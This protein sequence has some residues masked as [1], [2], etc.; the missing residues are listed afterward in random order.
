M[1][2]ANFTQKLRSALLLIGAI[3]GFSNFAWADLNTTVTVAS[4]TYTPGGTSSVTLEVTIA[5][6]TVEY[7]S[8]LTITLPAGWTGTFNGLGVGSGSCGS[9]TGVVCQDGGNVLIIGDPTCAPADLCGPWNNGTFQ[10]GIDITAPA[11]ATGTQSISW[12]M[13]GDG[14][15]CGGACSCGDWTCDNGTFDLLSS[16]CDIT[17]PADITVDNDPGVC[18]ADVTVPD[19]VVD[20]GCAG[21]PADYITV[22]SPV[23]PYNFDAA[24][25]IA[26]P[27]TVSG[28]TANAVD[29]AVITATYTGD[30]DFFF[31]TE[32]F[33]VTGPDG[34][35]VFDVGISPGQCAQNS[36]TT[37]IPMATWNNWVT[38][39]GA[40]LTFTLQA[41][42]DVDDICA[43]S[44]YQLDVTYPQIL[45]AFSNDFNGGENASGEYPVGTTT[46]TYSTLNTNGDVVS[47]SFNVTVNDVEAPVFQNCPQ[48]MVFNLDPGACNTVVTWPEIIAE[49]NCP[50]VGPA[51]SLIQYSDATIDMSGSLACYTAPTGYWRVFDLAAM[52]I[53]SDFQVNSVSTALVNANNAAF[54][55]RVYTLSGAFTLA[56]L[57]LLGEKTAN[58]T[59]NGVFGDIVFDTPVIVPAGSTMV[60]EVNVLPNAPFGP[61]GQNTTGTETGAS[62][63]SAPSCGINDPVTFASIGFPQYIALIHPNGNVFQNTIPLTNNSD[64][65]P[66]TGQ[67]Y[68]SGDEFPIGVTH[69]SFEATDASGNTSTCD[70]DVIVNEY[71]NPTA[72]LACNDG[73]Q[74][75]LDEDGCSTVGADMVLEGGPY[76]C[77][78]DYIVSIEGGDDVVCCDDLGG[79]WTVKV[80]DPDTGNSCWGSI[81]VEDKLD[82]VIECTDAFI[83]CNEDIAYGVEFT[84][85][86]NLHSGPQPSYDASSMEFTFD[87]SAPL[88]A[89]VNDV[90]VSLD[91]SHTWVSDLNVFLLAP[92]GTPVELFT[93]VCGLDDNIDVTIDDDGSPFACSGGNP[94]IA[95]VMQPENYPAQALAT[96]NGMNPNGTWTLRIQDAFGGDPT[97]INDLVLNINYT[98]SWEAPVASDNCTIVSM[99]YNDDVEASDCSGASEI[100][101]R[102]WTVIDQSGNSATCTQTI[103]RVRPTIAD[104]ELPSNYDDM[105]LPHLDCSGDY[106]DLN[107]NGYPDVDEVDQP[108][109]GGLTWDNNSVCNLSVVYED[110]VIPICDGSFKVRRQWLILDW[111]TGEEIEYNQLIKVLDTTGP[112][113]ADCPTEPVTIPVYQGTGQSGNY[114]V[115]TGNV[116]IPPITVTGDDC[117]ALDPDSYLTELWDA[118][119]TN[120]LQVISGNGG[121]FTDVELIADNPPTNNATYVVKHR[122]YDS[123]GNES[124]CVYTIILE[125]KVPP[126]AICDEITELAITNAGGSGEGCSTIPAEN[127]D[128]GSYDNCGDVYFLAAK[129]NPFLQP[130]Y[131]YQYYPSLEYCCDEVG[132]NMAILLV[133]DFDPSDYLLPD[134]SLFLL[135]G[136]AA[137]EGHINFCMVTIQVTDKIPPVLLT[138]PDDVTMTCDEYLETLASDLELGNLEVLD[139]FGAASFYDNCQYD[140][141]YD[142][143]VDIDNCTSGTITR[144]WTA[145]DANG[146]ASC[147]QTIYVQHVSDWVVEF[148]EN[149]TA[150]CVDGQLPDFGEP[151][152]T[153]DE[154]ELIGVSYQDEQFDVVPDACYK[155]IRHWS[156]INWCVFDQYGSDVYSEAGHY[157]AAYYQDWDGDGDQD[158]RTF[159]EGYNDAGIADGYITY[160][161]VI[162]VVDNEAPIFNV[163]DQTYCIEETDCD[164]DITLPTPDVT[165]CSTGIEITVTSDDLAAYATGDQ[166]SFSNVP[167][168]EY[169]VNY[170]VTD[171]CGNTSYDE[172]VVTVVD[173][174]KPTPYCV[175]G[176][177]IEIMQTGMVQTWA[178]DFDAGS[179]DNCP[180]DL[181]LS[182]SPDVNDVGITFTCDDLGQQPIELWVTDAAGNQDFCAT[183]IEVQD[184]MGACGSPTVAGIVATEEDEPVADVQVDVNGGQYSQTTG[185][186]G[187]FSFQL[188]EGGD[189]TLAP[190]LDEDPL[191]GVSTLD[192]VYIMR[193]ILQ[194]D[195]LDSPYQMI[196]ADVNNSHGISTLDLVALQ[197]V[198]LLVEPSFPNNTS[199]RFVDAD[200]VFPNPM[201]PWAEVFPEVIN[202][203][204]LTN[205]DPNADF[206][207]IKIGD[208]NGSVQANATDNA[209]E[210]NT[211]AGDMII[212]V[213]DRAVKAGEKFTVDFTADQAEVTGYQFTL[214]FDASALE[215]ADVAYGEENLGLALLDEGAITVSWA[216]GEV[217]DLRGQVL[218][219][220]VFKAKSSGEL[221][222]MF[223]ISSRYVKA[224]AYNGNDEMLNVQL[225]IDGQVQA[226]EFTLYQNSPNPFKD[227]TVI[228]FYLPEASATTLTIMDVSGKIIRVIKG[229]YDKGYHEVSVSKLNATGVLYYKLE[230]ANETATRKMVIME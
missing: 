230:T 163:D 116:V 177:V 38:T 182:F 27:T 97:N 113:L 32:R 57:T 143:T 144:T 84:K 194:T 167:P 195:L 190:G 154:C 39:Y 40:N 164:T 98:G 74:I 158:T 141:T 170:E 59:G 58:L 109:I 185:N 206:V 110:L 49:D 24:G 21:I 145:S 64:I 198:I 203:N 46:V 172:I 121:V 62:Y 221:S 162:K 4:G 131:F 35:T 117:S 7:G 13:E 202:Y 1:K 220:L 178:S 209:V 134:G 42:P 123:C 11:S 93:G 160:D 193:H 199:W 47:C 216:N 23:T 224:E 9:G 176:L 105:D 54:T 187:T 15:N 8:L 217:A 71:A 156:V 147:T 26:T 102:T 18:G 67:P 85:D 20:P 76:G 43:S 207:G 125:D 52:G 122:V 45:A 171:N 183:Y 174:K 55:A 129:M 208:V 184:N 92:D 126:V 77:Y 155:I 36:A 189:Y 180:G 12:L 119:G 120:L 28:A 63:I 214:N 153:H 223:S 205:D 101:H 66:E 213:A 3:I 181:K 149:I 226:D 33:T 229:Q 227:E 130:P 150:Q 19:A 53:T 152:I 112:E 142:V 22:S 44:E 136:Q 138:C 219:S 107:D 69:M 212:G 96:F 29:D 82:P 100:I 211:V 169:V 118:T 106:W 37:T 10:I 90:N 173:C 95:G 103:T 222:D 215:L 128:D 201:N 91:I 99:D 115:C 14:W 114:G 146:T 94:A 88:N 51:T 165:D 6:T 133:L 81:V 151:V 197:K 68:T 83:N 25:L 80:T 127:L 86:L 159:R 2:S 148:P 48:D 104:V 65:N 135:P 111:C 16:A 186:D 218:F 31:G 200:Y 140:D 56:N 79:P 87:V 108:T 191:N 61:A 210:F 132:D 124:E 72:T 192:M 70:F 196:A 228:G 30:H 78:D 34:S 137:F 166:Y 17:C 168:G 89:T 225:S 179:F 188:P 157:E 5:S 73:V 75:S 175:E 60:I 41:D 50:Y 204:N 161:Q 139:Q